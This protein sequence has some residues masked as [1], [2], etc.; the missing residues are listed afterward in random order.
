MK[1]VI[2]GLRVLSTFFDISKVK[3][4]QW[5]TSAIS[6]AGDVWDS[7]SSGAAKL[8]ATIKASFIDPM[9]D[10]ILELPNLVATKIN[11]A[12]DFVRDK[13]PGAGFFFGDEEENKSVTESGTRRTTTL[14]E[15]ASADVLSESLRQKRTTAPASANDIGQSVGKSV[16]SAAGGGGQSG[17]NINVSVDITGRISGR[18]LNLAVTRQQ[19]EV[20]EKNGIHTNPTAKRKV[21]QNGQMLTGTGT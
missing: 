15:R 3:F 21:K 9:R 5:K 2:T 16:A 6:A 14:V 18:D 13:V 1:A 12:R 20:A 11:A 19:V 8:W 7:F 10:A 4:N 17:S